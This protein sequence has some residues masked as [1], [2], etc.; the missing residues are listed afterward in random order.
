MHVPRALATLPPPPRTRTIVERDEVGGGPK[1]RL[2]GATV[3]FLLLLLHFTFV[4][5]SSA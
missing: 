2:Q 4:E 3:V 1:Y 5:N